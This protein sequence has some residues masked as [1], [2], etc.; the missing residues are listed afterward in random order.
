MLHLPF[1]YSYMT[2]QGMWAKAFENQT[3]FMT[4]LMTGVVQK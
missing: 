2:I 4:A 3:K 1:V